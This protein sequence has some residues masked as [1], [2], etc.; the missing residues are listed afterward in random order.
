MLMV[1]MG[2]QAISQESLKEVVTNEGFAWMAGRWKATTDEGQELLLVYQWTLNGHA[3]ISDFKMGDDYMSHGIIYYLSSDEKVLQVTV[4]SRG[5]NTKSE[6]K[7]DEDKAVSIT[8]GK[9]EWGE[10]TVMAIV[11]SKVDNN[12]MKVEL[13]PVE[14][15]QVGDTP[16]TGVE[17]KRQVKPTTSTTRKKDPPAIL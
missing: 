7:I 4:D 14:N 13:C 5:L 16:V 2:S 17:F 10:T 9:D 12:T 3:I 8:E 1:V 11:H 15:G 6:W